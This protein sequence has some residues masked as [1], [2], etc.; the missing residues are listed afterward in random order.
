MKKLLPTLLLVGFIIP[1]IVLAAWWK[2]TNWFSGWSFLHR[3][4][5]DKTQ[6]LENRILE[7]ERKLNET[8]TA[9]TS[10]AAVKETENQKVIQTIDKKS[11]VSPQ[12][13]INTESKTA[14]VKANFVQKISIEDLI[15]KYT[16][17]QKDIVLVKKQTD[18]FSKLSTEVA[19]YKYI[20]SLLNSI[21]AD[22]GYLGSVKYYS[23]IPPDIETTYT[24]KFNSLQNDYKIEA[25][26]Y[27]VER[28]QNELDSAKSEV[29]TYIK[30]NKQ[31]LYMNEVHIQAAA[32]LYIFDQ[33]AGTKY[34]IDFESKKTQQET[35]EFANRFLID[36]D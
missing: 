4:N 32:L 28:N 7:L 29:V 16:S 27:S 19:Y 34:A 14:E 5:E 10:T 25:N 22:L 30:N 15:I 35:I 21:N 2:P 26:R 36:Q 1:N 18:Q 11:T 33:L 31:T 12:M 24:N 9:T 13:I 23:K 8:Q 20:S 3:K 6:V 17:F